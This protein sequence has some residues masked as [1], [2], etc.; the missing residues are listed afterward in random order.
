MSAKRTAVCPFC[1]GRIFAGDKAMNSKISSTQDIT[2]TTLAV[3]CIGILIAASFWILRPFLAAFIWA[4]MIVVATWPLLLILQARLWG[5]RSLAVAVMTALLLLIFIVPFS[6]AVAAIV[7]KAD[8]IIAWARSLTTFTLPP[9]PGWLASVPLFGSKLS[10]QWQQLAV[11]GPSGLSAHLAPYAGKLVR[12]FVDQAGGLGIMIFQ[13]LLTVIIAAI[14]YANGETAAVG[15]VSFARRLAGEKGEEVAV[16]A[17]K[18]VRGVALGVVLTA[19]IQSGL[20]GIGLAVTGLPAATILT[21]VMFM[22]CIAQIG[23]AP[24]LIPAVVWLYY[25]SGSLWGTVLLIWTIPVLILDNV[26]RPILI[27]KG[28]DL[29]LL[30]IFAGVIGGL[31]AIGIIGLFIGPVVLA[32]SYTLAKAWVAGAKMESRNE[33]EKEPVVPPIES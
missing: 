32:V 23:P 14:L 18:A 8:E 26:L 3:L 22:F 15:V 28:A 29:P 21:A 25:A 20:G 6:L 27:R 2:R 9:P 4:T 31:F 1:I 16:L 24:V 12:W 30:L 5:R 33:G 7:D 10:E 19:I 11:S 17:A 13:F